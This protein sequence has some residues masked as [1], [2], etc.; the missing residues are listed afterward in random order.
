MY[1]KGGNLCVGKIYANY[2]ESNKKKF[3]KPKNLHKIHHYKI[4]QI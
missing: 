1:T 2:V 4:K 3:Q